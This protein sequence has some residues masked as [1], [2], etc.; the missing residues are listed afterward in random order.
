[1]QDIR[2]VNTN[3]FVRSGQQSLGTSEATGSEVASAKALSEG[4]VEEDQ[5][6]FAGNGGSMAP[7]IGMQGGIQGIGQLSAS[8]LD[9]GVMQTSLPSNYWR[10]AFET[11]SEQTTSVLKGRENKGLETQGHD[12]ALGNGS[13]PTGG[14]HFLSAD[15]DRLGSG[16]D[17]QLDFNGMLMNQVMRVP[18]MLSNM[19]SNL[20][21]KA[22]ALDGEA[23][24]KS[25]AP[26]ASKMRIDGSGN[27]VL[28]SSKQS[29]GG[30]TKHKKS[31]M[32]IL[33]ELTQQ[34]LNH[35]QGMMH[36]QKLFQSMGILNQIQPLGLVN[37]FFPPEEVV[38]QKQ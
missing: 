26:S 10:Q 17:H 3:T 12:A 9:T 37:E 36:A 23:S 25:G 29:A 6:G 8:A 16:L 31:S 4:K 20:A 24:E 11:R 33:N 22:V 5:G 1:M 2:L 7:T 34:Q 21:P 35:E 15:V 14:Q 38:Q 27:V 30:E 19:F 13:D 32:D 28:S 18:T